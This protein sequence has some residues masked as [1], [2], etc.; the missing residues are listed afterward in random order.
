MK[1]SRWLAF[2]LLMSA[3]SD[4][5]AVEPE[6]REPLKPEREAA[7][8]AGEQRGTD[9]DAKPVA[10]RPGES[11]EQKDE[12]A[13]A[14]GPVTL[15]AAQAGVNADGAILQDFNAR[16]KKYVDIHKDAA[17]GSGKQKQAEDPAEIT[18]AQG[19]LASR[20]QAV[21]AHAQQ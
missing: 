2:A 8:T 15:A 17:K 18:K 1:V 19:V 20:I 7:A 3:C 11:A 10:R 12:R 9:P 21:R 6:P 16:V 14:T 5:P 4:G 13:A